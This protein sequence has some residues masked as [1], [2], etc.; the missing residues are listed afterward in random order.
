M[1][2]VLQIAE[3]G[4]EEACARQ[5]NGDGFCWA[6][7]DAFAEMFPGAN[8]GAYQSFEY[9]NTIICVATRDAG[10]PPNAKW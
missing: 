7:I 3:L 5:A 6:T 2:T 1:V 9:E 8:P 4:K 10:V